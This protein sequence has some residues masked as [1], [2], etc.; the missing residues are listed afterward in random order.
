MASLK[1]YF[2]VTT[3]S[4]MMWM[5]IGEMIAYDFDTIDLLFSD[6]KVRSYLHSEVVPYNLVPVIV[7]PVEDRCHRRGDPVKI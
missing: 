1:T 5:H 7:L 2:Q 3:R 4:K 6:G